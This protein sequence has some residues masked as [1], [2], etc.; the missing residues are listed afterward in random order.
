[1]RRDVIGF[2]LVVTVL[3]V[4]ASFGPGCGHADAEPP[5]RMAAMTPPHA[6]RTT[7]TRPSDADIKKMLTPMQYE[8]TQHEG[9]EP[10]F[11]NE[12]WDNHAAGIYVDVVTGEPL[13][14]SQDKFDSGTGWPSF[15]RPI[16]AGRVVMRTDADG[17]RSE[18]RSHVGDSHLGHV[19]D[20]GP[21]PTGKRFCIDSAALR[22]VPA[23]QLAHDG[24]GA[25]AAAFP[26]AREVAI[27]A[28]GC[29]WGMEN[30]MRQAPGVISVEVGYAG[31]VSSKVSYEDVS[32]GDTGHAESVRI[33]FD[34]TQ[35]S[36]QDLLLHWYF[37]GHDPTTKD[38]QN[39]DV[40]TQYRSEIFTTS[41][42]QL[43]TAQAVKARVDK[44][45]KW[46]SPVVTLIAPA[47]T[48]VRAE[49]YHQDYLI[50][51]PNGY[52]DHYL[53]PFDY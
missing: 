16:E 35:I 31:G 37:R 11:H 30:I 33:V 21:A 39:N 24:Y 36:Y 41:D 27:V 12:Y 14:S 19:F 3:T 2:G 5:Q 25:Y 51:N 50:K 6:A 43:K 1:M 23:A 46:R 17:E 42:A 34:P 26:Q 40:G 45:G 18:V 52:N 22:F 47:T 10:S 4:F 38:R 44:S 32:D 8:I 48:F 9:T 29:F 20:D 28:G 53:R 13:F 49:D 7:F 15:T